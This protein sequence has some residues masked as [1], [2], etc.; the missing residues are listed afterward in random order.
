VHR[1]EV[2]LFAFPQGAEVI[3]EPHVNAAPQHREIWLRDPDG[4][5][6]VVAG[7]DDWGES[8]G[9]TRVIPGLTFWGFQ[10][11]PISAELSQ[12]RGIRAKTGKVIKLTSN[13]EPKSM[14]KKLMALATERLID[15]SHRSPHAGDS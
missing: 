14:A 5:V 11:P 3:E 10:T 8:A 13:L 7:P 15:R 1:Q 4:Y 12:G 2:E 6:V 9:Y